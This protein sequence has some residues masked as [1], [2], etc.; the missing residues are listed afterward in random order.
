MAF[1][2][3][4]YLNTNVLHRSALL[5]AIDSVNEMGI[6]HE[7]ITVVVSTR[8]MI[9]VLPQVV[10]SGMKTV[11]NIVGFGRLYSDY[12]IIGRF[13]FN[14]IV[15]FHDRTTARA[16]IV[17]HD[18]DKALLERFVR[19]PVF[20]THGSG[21]ETEGFI[22]KKK[23]PGKITKIGYL[24]RFDESK[25]SDEVLKLAESLPDGRQLII[26]GWDIKGSRYTKKF[27]AISKIKNNIKFIGR[28]NSRQEISDF[29]NMI[30][31]FLSPSRR[32]GGN[33]SLQEAIWHGVPFF[34]TDVPGC[35]VLAKIF[36]CPAVKLSN[37]ADEVVKYDTLENHVDTSDWGKK[38]RPF[39][40]EQV[41]NEYRRAFLSLITDV[42]K[43]SQKTS[44]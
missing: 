32:E 22:H 5:R 35:S 44:G 43:V 2:I 4:D 33:I 20:T 21:L 27:Q 6:D 19:C 42:Q 8:N 28:L 3:F 31:L 7:D 24:S 11:I 18:V 13:V 25:G 9:R 36:G 1:F 38:L 29:F 17:E 16:F 41:C 30:D 37:F 39:L 23:I 14:F 12:G 40:V 10:F 26:A 34:T 15:W